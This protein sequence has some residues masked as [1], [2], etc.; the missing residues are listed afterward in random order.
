VA[1]SPDSRLV[2]TASSDG[3][4]RLWTTADSS[5]AQTLTG[6]ESPVRD[7]AF[8]PDGRT[9]ATGAQDG[10]VR[11]W[12]VGSGRPLLTLTGHLGPVLS[13]AVSPDEPRL[14]TAA[15]DGTVRVWD[16]RD[17]QEVLALK[18]PAEGGGRAWFSSDGARLVGGF[19]RRPVVWDAGGT[20]LDR[21]RVMLARLDRRLGAEPDDAAARQARAALRAAQGDWH[22]A[23]EDFAHLAQRAGADASP[24]LDTGWWLARARAADT[25]E[26][27]GGVP[28]PSRPAPDAAGAPVL[29]PGVPDV[30]GRLDLGTLPDVYAVAWLYV[31]GARRQAATLG[32]GLNPRVWL[33]GEVVHDGGELLAGP[34]V[35]LSLPLRDGWNTLIGQPVRRGEDDFLDLRL[36][37]KPLTPAEWKEPAPLS[38]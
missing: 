38:R 17:G 34:A 35:H 2:A 26:F 7:V 22:G 13:V 19:P 24:R 23:G 6:H 30:S 20:A 36:G 29:W 12:D 25:Q 15:L 27:L 9:L 4:A 32:P 16:T 31:R 8:S 11:L 5:L 21:P 37:G 14:A 18:A 1:F 10:K 28:D 3:T 33:N